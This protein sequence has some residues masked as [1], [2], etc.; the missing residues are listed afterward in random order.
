VKGL[1]GVKD[2]YTLGE[3]VF[4][5][6]SNGTVRAWGDNYHGRLGDG[7]YKTRTKPVK[8]KRLSGVVDI[9]MSHEGL[10]YALTEK[11][12]LWQWGPSNPE[13]VDSESGVSIYTKPVK[14]R[15]LKGVT[16]FEDGYAITR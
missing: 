15:N 12:V 10:S 1:S 6:K 9:Y 7:T 16:S 3:S 11:G 2:V 8:V 5:L 4:A 13:G 14:I